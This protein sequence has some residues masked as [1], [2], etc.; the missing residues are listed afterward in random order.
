V[1]GEIGGV[2]CRVGVT[3][4]DAVDAGI[5]PSRELIG[6]ERILVLRCFGTG[7]AV[8]TTGPDKE[9]GES[10]IFRSTV[11]SRSSRLTRSAPSAASP[12]PRRAS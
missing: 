2:F 7:N 3:S 5:A 8:K 10:G 11:S 1:A 6:Q 12:N 9:S 4:E